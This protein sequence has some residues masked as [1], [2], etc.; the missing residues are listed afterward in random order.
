MQK[1]VNLH[2]E[3]KRGIYMLDTENISMNYIKKENLY[4]SADGIRYMMCKKDDELVVCVW[5][6]PLGYLATR[7]DLKEYKN[8]TFDSNGKAE[9][10]EYLNQKIIALAD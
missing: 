2:L 9:A 7:E 10:I 1:Y 6:E 5:P 8:F 3:Y 4:G